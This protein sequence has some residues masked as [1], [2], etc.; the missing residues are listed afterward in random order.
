M[1]MM[2]GM[3]MDMSDDPMFLD[4]NQ[5]LARGFWY[6]VTFVVATLLVLRLIVNYQNWSRSVESSR[7]FSLN[8]LCTPS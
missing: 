4:Y 3:G 6:C 5:A 8:H 7:R 2:D 1:S